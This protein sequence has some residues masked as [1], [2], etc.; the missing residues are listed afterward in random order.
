[1]FSIKINGKRFEHFTDFSCTLN[2]GAIASTFGFSALFEPSSAEH[3]RLFKPFSYNSI[4]VYYNGEL[5]I[6]GIALSPTFTSEAKPTLTTISGYSKT[7]VLEDCT[8][9]KS[10]Y[11]LQF[12]GM[13]FREIATSILNKFNLKLIVDESVLSEV[14]TSYDSVEI[15]ETQKIKSFL[16]EL[17]VQRNMILTHTNNGDVLITR[18]NTN[19][20]VSQNFNQ[21]MTGY[22][23]SLSTNGQ[24]MF[25]EVYAL[26]DQDIELD[27]AG[28]SIDSNPY[29]SAFRPATV[30]QTTGDDVTTPNISR[31]ALGAMIKNSIRLAIQSSQANW[32]NGK[33]IKPSDIITV[34]NPDL[35]LF[36]STKFFVDSVT[37]TQGKAQ[38]TATIQCVLPESYNNE[39]I[40]NVFN[41]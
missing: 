34:T 7:G 35:Y 12:E 28:D 4:Q 40:T 29:V 2:F 1:M 26:K 41:S 16:T 17:A 13:T 27:N 38:D 21:G 32:T 24:S 6:N 8:A 11:P 9:P 33:L 30:K 14:D 15:N 25:S 31:M 19:K 20:K 3:R 5:L 10:L 36:K 23:Q 22:K 37:L 39:P 18:V